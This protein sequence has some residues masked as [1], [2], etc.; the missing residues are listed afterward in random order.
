MSFNIKYFW[1]EQ[2]MKNKLKVG[3]VI[4]LTRKQ[5]Q[6]LTDT[7]L[8]AAKETFE[9]LRRWRYLSLRSSVRL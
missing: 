8:K 4:K 1:E 7:P 6:S 9:E 5:N 3:K 2:Q